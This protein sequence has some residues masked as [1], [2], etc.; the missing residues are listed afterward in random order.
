MPLAERNVSQQIRVYLL[1]PRPKP[2]RG[3]KCIFNFNFLCIQIID[4]FNAYLLLPITLR[5]RQ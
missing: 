5:G 3:K 4:E 1:D 2:P